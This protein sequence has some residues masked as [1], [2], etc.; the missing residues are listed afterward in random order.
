MTS[1]TWNSVFTN[2]EFI[3]SQIVSNART[4]FSEDVADLISDAA[5]LILINAGLNDVAIKTSLLPQ[6]AELTLDG[7]ASYTLPTLLNE[8]NEVYWFNTPTTPQFLLFSPLADITDR[9]GYQTSTP[10]YYQIN[11][12]SSL[13]LLG[14]G[15]STGTLRLYG[16]KRPTQL[17][18][19]SD[20]VDLPIEYIEG[21]YLWLIK[22]YFARRRVPDELIYWSQ[23]YDKAIDFIADDVRKRYFSKG[24]FYGL[25]NT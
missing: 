11:G 24:S 5:L 17:T 6:Y 14:S 13:S 4:R 21:L 22:W 3:G 25:P 7:S 1:F 18:S 15:S 9:G 23:E 12:N 8:R 16:T 20:Y 2:T 10:Q 19:L